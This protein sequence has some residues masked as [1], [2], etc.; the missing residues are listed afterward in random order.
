MGRKILWFI[1]VVIFNILA[2]I[3]QHAPANLIIGLGGGMNLLVVSLNNFKMPVRGID[4]SK[5][6][7][8]QNMTPDTKLKFLADII[9]TPWAIYSIGD[10]FIYAGL[11]G[12]LYRIFVMFGG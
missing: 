6:K 10:L 4:C 5:D 1:P 2:G 12:L 8:H 9:R 7:K 3:F 11:F